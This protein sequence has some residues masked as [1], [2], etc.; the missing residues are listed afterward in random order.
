MIPWWV[1]AIAVFGTNFTLWGLIGL[2]RV[3]DTSTRR[4]WQRRGKTAPADQSAV[5]G[6]YRLLTDPP[7]RPGVEDVAVLMAAHN[8]ETVIVD[9]IQAITALVPP[10]NV[11]V[12]SDGSTDRTVELAQGCGVNVISTAR[13]VGKAGALQEAIR[14]FDLAGRFEVVMLLDAD[15]HVDPG[16]FRAALPLFEDPDVVAVAGCVKTSWQDRALG[17]IGKLVAFHRQR[18]YTMTQYLLKFG[19]TWRR[20]NATHIVPGFASMYRTS[21][22]PHIEVNPPGLVIEDFNMTFE[23]YQKRLGKVGF[24]PSAVAATQD[25]GNLKDYVKQCKRWAL[26]LW[27]TVRLHPPRV[28]LFSLMLALLLME[29]LTS[30]VLLVLL[31]FVA[32]VLVVPELFSGVLAVPGVS[33]VHAFIAGFATLPS[34]LFGV[35]IPDLMLTC[36]VALLQR[37][38]RFLLFG[39]FFLMLRVLDAAVALYAIPGAWL[40]KSSGRWR[41]PG[42]RAIDPV[43]SPVPPPADLSAS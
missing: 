15:T 24:T 4:W 1:L 30:S 12:V 36:I 21:V 7:R 10:E 6:R 18:I 43:T 3:L 32:A 8:E 35:L 22:L 28:N 5:S 38:P 13:N 2:M 19:Q 25:P 37:Q 29:M 41:S 39:C 27:Q 34:L 17:P 16:Y 42:R 40:S 20:V 33:E 14:R 9:S 23:V 26:G 31:P 11:H